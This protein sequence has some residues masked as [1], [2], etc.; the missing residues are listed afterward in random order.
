GTREV[1]VPTKRRKGSGK[2]LTVHK[3]TAINLQGVTASIPVGTFTCVLL[4][5]DEVGRDV[6]VEP[7]DRPVTAAVSPTGLRR[8]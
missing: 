5:D 7:H 1:A 2:K 3:A 8:F 4:Y 6:P